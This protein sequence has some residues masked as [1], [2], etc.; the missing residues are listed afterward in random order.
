MRAVAKLGGVRDG[1]RIEGVAR[2]ASVRTESV[3]DRLFH[4]LELRNG[5]GAIQA[6]VDET[7]QPNTTIHV[8]VSVHVNGT[9]ELL[10][11]GGPL[12]L[13]LDEI[14]V[15]R[16]QESLCAAER[17]RMQDEHPEEILGLD[18]GLAAYL[19][20]LLAADLGRWTPQRRSRLTREEV[21]GFAHFLSD[22]LPPSLRTPVPTKPA[23]PAAP[24][25]VRP[26]R[27]RAAWSHYTC[28]H[29]AGWGQIYL[30][31]MTMNQI[32]CRSCGGTG[33]VTAWRGSVESYSLGA[34]YPREVEEPCEDCHG[35][36][37]E[38]CSGCGGTPE[39]EDL[40][41]GQ[42]WCTE[43]WLRE[44]ESRRTHPVY[45]GDPLAGDGEDNDGLPE[46][47]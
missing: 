39:I 47:W 25:R 27:S 19:L 13:H 8:G 36:G 11:E 41:E 42:P 28:P 20:W 29:P 18:R 12:A 24:A 26:G 2:V 43:C 9:A 3:D 14:H 40:E 46:G 10:W 22:A 21:L 6:V 35:T 37:V 16:P 4:V 34:I 44:R 15:V 30:L 17:P 23:K 1:D 32:K 5:T 7:A 33:C 31:V 38:S 45:T